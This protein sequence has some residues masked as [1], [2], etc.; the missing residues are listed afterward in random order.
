M[1][2]LFFSIALIFIFSCNRSSVNNTKD[3]VSKNDTA[4][5]VNESICNV[6]YDSSLLKYANNFKATTIRL[7]KSLSS[8]LDSF[9][10]F[11]D[12]NCL[13]KQ[14]NYSLFIATVLAK[15]YCHHLKCCNQGYDL[16]SLEQGSAKII[17]EDFKK[18][19]G[20]QNQRLDMLNSG[21]VEDFIESRQDLKSNSQLKEIVKEIEKEL[22]RLDKGNL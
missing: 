15:L 16:Q 21:T 3:T 22:T 2:L 12:T 19:A 11:V 6:D 1:R 10:L 8:E 14:K 20:Y 4:S 7:D 13:R 5:K 18:M 9:L 17:I